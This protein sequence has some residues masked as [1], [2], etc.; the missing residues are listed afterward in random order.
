ML[1]DP[2]IG[3]GAG[4]IDPDL[5]TN[6]NDDPKPFVRHKTADEILDASLLTVSGSLTQ[7]T[8]PR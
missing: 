4:R 1:K 6:W 7:D 2:S 5:E 3:Q 8:R